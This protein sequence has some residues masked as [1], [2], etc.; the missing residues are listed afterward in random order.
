MAPTTIV[1]IDLARSALIEQWAQLRS[2]AGQLDDDAWR[3]ASILPGWNVADVFAHII[4]TESLLAG[5]PVPDLDVSDAAHVHN[6]IGELN[7]RWLRHFAATSRPALIDAFDEIVAVR[8]AALTAMSQSDFDAETLT[9]AGPDS[10]G[11]FMRVRIFDCWM[12]DVDLRDSVQL[13][14]PTHERPARWAVTEIF[15]S[16]PYV[17]GKRAGA[18][19]GTRVRVT[20][21]GA[22]SA[23]ARVEVDQRARLVDDFGSAT[24]DC[25]LTVDAVEL[26][27]LVGGRSTANPMSITVAGDTDLGARIVDSLDYVI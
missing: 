7:E 11:R 16:L 6:P 3:R 17:I 12:H 8:T 2:L 9:P 22:T 1:P 26:A 19:Q 4:G 14:P 15:A 20:V 18:P 13:A 23:T 10:Y 25:T 21:A 5:R 24:A 27:R